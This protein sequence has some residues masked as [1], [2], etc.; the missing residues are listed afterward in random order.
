MTRST[1]ESS[2]EPQPDTVAHAFVRP[3]QS[4]DL[5]SQDEMASLASANRDLHELFRRCAL[6]VLNTGGDTDDARA[7]YQR[8]RDFDLRVVAESRGLKLELVNAP[9][10]AFVDGR[11]IVGIRNHLFAAL[12]DVVFTQRKIDRQLA[13]DLH[14]PAGIT[15]AVFRILRNANIVRSDVPPKLI[16]C[17]G[18]HA[19]SRAEYDFT[20][21]VGYQLGLRGLDIATGCGPGAMK[22]PMKGAAIGHAK[23]NTRDSRYVGITEP[24]IIAAESPN[25]IVNELVILPDIEKR[26]EAFVRLAHGIIVFPGGVGTAEEILF[27]LGVKLHPENAGMPLPL[28]FL[29]PEGSAGYFAEID[30]FLRSTLGNDIAAHY[31]IITGDPKT[32]ARRMKERVKEVRRHRVKRKE[33]FS[34]NWDLV[35][36][37]PLQQPFMPTH[38]NMAELRLESAMPTHDLV[39]A[40]RCAFSGIVAGNVKDFGVQAVEAHGPFLLHGDP[41]IGE[42]LNR[43]LAGFVAQGRMKL[44]ADSYAPC[45][46]LRQSPRGT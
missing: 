20:K 27:L 23:Q 43:L 8:Y 25:P 44:D 1:L 18:G 2:T 28:F 33:S 5:L 12:R 9:A 40:L 21:Q 24:G 32:A 35:I 34:F 36:P 3:L 31:D 37:E 42:R 10:E 41:E 15:D 26:L 22:G 46:E 29:A 45:F 6:A 13:F 38:E 30:D 19:I 14:S 7:V 11:M 16:V 17:W 4:L 39:R